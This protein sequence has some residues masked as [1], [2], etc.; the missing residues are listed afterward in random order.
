MIDLRIKFIELHKQIE[1]LRL[2]LKTKPTHHNVVEP[3]AGAHFTSIIETQYEEL[4]LA[5]NQ[6]LEYEARE[7]ASQLRWNNMLNVKLHD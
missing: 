1:L 5:K 2:K 4:C 6:L 7:T 3:T